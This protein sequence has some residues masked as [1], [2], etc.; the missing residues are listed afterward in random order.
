V[1]NLQNPSM[2]CDDTNKSLEL[3]FWPM[4]YDSIV[5]LCLQTFGSLSKTENSLRT[6]VK[7]ACFVYIRKVASFCIHRPICSDYSDFWK[8]IFQ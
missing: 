2:F 3:N 5:F 1:K 6:L 4:L 8:V 7:V